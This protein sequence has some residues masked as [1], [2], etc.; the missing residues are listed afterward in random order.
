MLIR[1]RL[2]VD[3]QPFSQWRPGLGERVEM[4]THGDGAPWGA[5]YL[6]HA[7]DRTASR[8]PFETKCLPRAMALH[9]MLRRRGARSQ[10]VIAVLQGVARGTMDDLHAWVESQGEVLIGAT[11]LP[12]HPII[13]FA[14]AQ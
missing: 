13:R 6:A 7:V 3:R 11:T 12:Y 14:V 5:R 8:L 1:A 2:L 4:P 9:A 10:I